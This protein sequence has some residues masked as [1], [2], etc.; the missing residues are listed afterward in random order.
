MAQENEP[1]P[2]INEQQYENIA[3]RNDAA[4]DDDAY[5]QALEAYRKHPINLNTA[6]ENDLENLQLL[7]ALQMQNFFSYRKL[8][9]K[10]LSIYELQ[11][12]PGWDINTIKSIFPFIKVSNE[13][14]FSEILRRRWKGGENY[15]LARTSLQLEKA[16][17][18]IKPIRP[19]SYYL[20]SPQK[21]FF[22]YKY[23][24]KDLMQFGLAG[25]KDAGEQF[26]KGTQKYGFDFYSFHFFSKN[27]GMVKSLAIGDFT[28]NLGQ[29]LIQWQGFA[30]AW[31]SNVLNIKR[32]SAVLRPY[33]SAGEFNFHRGAGITLQKGRW[34]A[35][36]F[37][38]LR[39]LSAN[40]VADSSGRQ[41]YVSSLQPSGYH[42][43]EAEIADRNLLRQTALGGNISFI[44]S[45]FRIGANVISYFFSKPIIKQSQPY[46]LFALQGKSWNNE[47]VDYSF[48]FRNI[49]FFGEAAVDKNF[50]SAFINGTL[51]SI[52]PTIDISLL[53]RKIDRAYQSLYANAFTKNTDVNNE[54][55][56]Y[57]SILVRPSSAWNIGAYFDIYKFPWLEYGVDAPGAGRDYLAQLNYQP[58]KIFSIYVRY[59]NE[60]KRHNTSNMSAPTHQLAFVSREG[61]RAEANIRIT[62]A[63]G[64]RNRV[65]AV[66]YNKQS[67][68]KEQGFTIFT[69]WRYAPFYK[70]FSCNLRLQYFETA[71]YNSRIYAYESDVL[72]YYAALS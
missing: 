59:K 22:R 8:F 35:T 12:I 58:N 29:G 49:H 18:Y 1:S 25:D 34:Q 15:L 20:G 27:M 39:K 41:D 60:R 21:I 46:N 13:Y 70:K 67:P 61:W 19:S 47:S 69:D 33:N 9:G 14:S 71:G 52:S 53:H 37:A 26:F 48:T 45:G 31:S 54:S 66:W 44:Q 42:R 2:L 63:I 23:Q 11:A 5:W 28:V 57:S 3:E 55:G 10:L 38:S 24:Y 72:Y 32:Q 17:G 4:T 6:E 36:A 64:C 30:F 43:T 50:H 51:I 65:E 62:K 16:K 56:F 40:L 7:T 68:D